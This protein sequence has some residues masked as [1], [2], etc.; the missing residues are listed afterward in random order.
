MTNFVEE[1]SITIFLAYSEY[2]AGLARW[3]SR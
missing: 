2:G 1:D 3:R